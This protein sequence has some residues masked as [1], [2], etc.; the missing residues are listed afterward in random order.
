MK[1]LQL[2]FQIIDIL[3]DDISFNDENKWDKQFI[4]TLYGKTIDDKNIVCN[5]KNYQP[6]FYLRIPDNWTISFVKDFLKIIRI[7]NYEK[8][9]I[10]INQYNNFYGFNYDPQCKKVKQYYFAKIYFKAYCDLQKCVREITK[11]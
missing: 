6:Y 9:K 2:Q 8:N 11:Y 4:L 7:Y 3:S 1:Q 10:E 5:V